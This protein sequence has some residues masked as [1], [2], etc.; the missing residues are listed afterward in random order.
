MKRILVTMLLCGFMP[1]AAYAGT[2]AA[3]TPIFSGQTINESTCG[4]EAGINM[5]GTI[6]GHPSQ[7]YS[8][9]ANNAAGAFTLTGTDREMSVT[10]SCT[11]API[12]SG[13][14]GVP[15]NASV[16][17]NGTSYLLIVSTDPS[18]PLANPPVCGAAS[19]VLPNPLPVSLQK[20]SV[21]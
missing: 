2:C 9:T 1:V 6:Y 11:S 18:I 19:T 13:A 7:V 4:G 10:T 14:P 3:P 17:V 16:L 5:G 20:F 12:A 15:I 8:F 21:E